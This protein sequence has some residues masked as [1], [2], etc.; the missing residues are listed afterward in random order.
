MDNPY[1]DFR[2]GLERRYINVQLHG[3]TRVHIY[4]YKSS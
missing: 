1:K 4:M 2:E 3:Y